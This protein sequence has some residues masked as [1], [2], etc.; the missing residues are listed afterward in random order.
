MDILRYSSPNI[1]AIE[2]NLIDE[3]LLGTPAIYPPQEVLEKMF[4]ILDIPEAEEL[5]A[6]A[7]EAVKLAIAER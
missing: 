5:Y 1:A 3:M 2:A 4:L 7:W 6:D